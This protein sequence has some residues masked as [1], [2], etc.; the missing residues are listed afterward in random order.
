MQTSKKK[1]ISEIKGVYIDR[2][3]CHGYIGALGK[4]NAKKFSINRLGKGEALRQAILWRRYKELEI[5]GHTNI[6]DELT[7]KSDSHEKM[8]EQILEQISQEKAEQD[9]ERQ[10]KREKVKKENKYDSEIAGKYIYRVDDIEIGYGWLLRIDVDNKVLCNTVFRDARYT[11]KAEGLKA[12]KKEREKILQQNNIPL[13]ENRKYSVGLRSTNKTGVR[14]VYRAKKKYVTWIYEKP[15]QV[16]RRS[17]GIHKYGEFEAFRKAVEWRRDK[18][19]E[20]YGGS[21]LTDE[22]LEKIFDNFHAA[23]C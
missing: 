13:A 11:S 5:R 21:I 16:K 7:F 6:A 23:Q 19:I 3:F 17:F 1:Y 9:K 22:Y 14:G 10:K 12:A 20:V 4:K 15:R 8:M 2:N 18:E